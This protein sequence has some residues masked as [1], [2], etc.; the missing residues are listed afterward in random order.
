MCCV[1]EFNSSTTVLQSDV[2]ENEHV[3]REALPFLSQTISYSRMAA[4]LHKLNESCRN[5]IYFHQAGSSLQD[6]LQAAK[7]IKNASDML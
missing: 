1:D 2:T 5:F 7:S 6:Q 3:Q 4:D